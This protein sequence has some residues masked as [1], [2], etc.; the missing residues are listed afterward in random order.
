MS[1][2]LRRVRAPAEP[3]ARDRAWGVVRTAY[4]DREPVQPRRH[5]GWALA[6]AAAAAALAA[7][8]VSSPGQAVLDSIRRAVG[9]ER[10]APALFSLPASGRLLVV[11]GGDAWVV[12]PDGSRR[13]LGRYREA[14][15]SPQGRFVAVTRRNELLAVDPKGTVRWS[16]ARADVRYPRWTGTSTDT[17]IVY[18][19]GSV[20]RLV[21]GDGTGDRR[22]CRLPLAARVAPAWRPGARRV[23]AYATARG[24]ILVVDADDCVIV[25]RTSARPIPR[26]LAWSDDG[27]RLVAAA[28]SAVRVLDG[29]ARELSRESPSDAT[30]AAAVAF[31]PGSH[32]L[33]EIRLHG[34]RSDVF[35]VGTR[36]GL[37]SGGGAFRDLAW[38][39]DGRWLLVTWPSADQWVFV[40]STGV[41]R[42]AAV[43]DIGRQFGGSFPTVSGWC[44][45]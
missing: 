22:L 33:A 32:E 9:I 23:L 17:R 24:E 11:A 44:C 15:W 16:L 38:S 14:S 39:P 42:L 27:R 8:A 37:F 26:Q 6:L 19:S 29:R 28:P 25:G 18:L 10:A 13:R 30:R 2:R 36:K 4:L 12:H 7:A 40:R 1:S 31:V 5:R 45:R 3:E 43:S 20:L 21:A 41:R 35:I 34:S